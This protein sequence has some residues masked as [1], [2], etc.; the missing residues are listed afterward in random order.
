MLP[1]F[2]TFIPNLLQIAPFVLVFALVFAKALRSYAGVFYAFFTCAV[3]LVSWHEPILTFMQEA[4][5]A[6]VVRYGAVL[7]S[8]IANS[9]FISTLVTLTTSSFT[10][11]SLY[12]IVMFIGAVDKTPWVKRLFSI[13]SEL[14]I[15]GGIIIVGH[16]VRTI[17]FAVMTASP[18][19]ASV[20]GEPSSYFMFIAGVIIGPLLTITFL[21]P[22]ITSFKAVRKRM[23]HTSWKKVQK[24]AYPFMALMV[25]QGLFLALG[26]CFYGYPFDSPSLAMSLM[27]GSTLWLETFAQQVAT[28]WMYLFIGVAY[29]VLRVRKSLR[30][31]AR[32]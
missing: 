19:A 15:L 20:W 18:G 10:G 25:A 3:V 6:F 7:D 26:H 5:P 12:L 9:P 4:S 13:R 16:L 2:P 8:A 29:L 23:T 30:T 11:V 28:A 27:S 31:R 21:V 1:F 14:S 32:Q 17:S 22:W 24:L